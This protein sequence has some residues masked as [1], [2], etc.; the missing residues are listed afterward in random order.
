MEDIATY[1]IVFG[2]LIGGVSFWQIRRRK[3][4]PFV[5]S[6]QHYP[7]LQLGIIVRKREVKSKDL[8]VEVRCH[9]ALEISGVFVEMIS[10]SREIGKLETSAL[11]PQAGRTVVLAKNQ[12]IQFVYLFEPFKKY[13]K[14]SGLP[15]RTFRVVVETQSH[16][17]YKSHEMAFNKNWG[18]FRPDSGSYN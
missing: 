7:E 15:M 8:V 2:L 5:L 17:K 14:D 9:K 12:K 6:M 18:L 1:L 13:L 4:R 10:K 3:P 11:L 16:K